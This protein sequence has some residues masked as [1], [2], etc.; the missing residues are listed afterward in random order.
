MRKSITA[1]FT[2][3]LLCGFASRAERIDEILTSIAANNV[4]LKAMLKDAEARNDDNRADNTLGGPSVEYSPF[5][6]KNVAGLSSSELIVSQ[7]FDFPTLYA[8]RSKS[9]G[10]QAKAM[11]LQYDAARRDV[12]LE[13]K[14]LCID[15]VRLRNERE[16]IEKR[17]GYACSVLEMLERKEQAG[18]TTALEV[19]KSRMEKMSM[20]AAAQLNQSQQLSVME[21]LV[22]MNGSDSIAFDGIDYPAEPV[23]ADYK[24]YCARALSYDAAIVAARGE[25]A[26]A[27][28]EVNVSRQSWLPA[29]NM[30]FRRNTA[31][32]ESQN[33]F[34][35]GLSFPVWSSKY[36]VRAAH[37]RQV[38]A[39]LRAEDAERTT[40][41]R[42][43]AEY[44]EF[45]TLGKTIRAYDGEL[46]TETLR[47]LAKAVEAGQITV[48]EYF[49]E[50]DV[51]YG[52]MQELIEARYK[53]HTVM[54]SL[55]RS[56]L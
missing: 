25:V 46:M 9:S 27:R 13:A 47:L 26:A 49:N 42:M 48:L 24:E 37:A 20:E 5:W 7:E 45:V 38:A 29:I 30:G 18:A 56:D 8:A 33:G 54:A 11:S 14:Q 50:S 41:T 3:I 15:L 6:Q 4:E 2:A 53:Y 16:L 12:L 19:N 28:Q 43:Q 23:L 52:K 10:L 22:A 36:R 35:V 21:A 40:E 17:L 55:T 31:P 39:E 1:A 32:G 51:V 44:Q 34:V